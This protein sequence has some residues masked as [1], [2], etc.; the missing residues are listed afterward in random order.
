MGL[1]DD[2]IREHL[3]L[4]RRHGADPDEVSRQED[5]ALG[6]VRREPVATEEE[7]RPGPQLVDAAHEVD[8]DL[9][10]PAGALPDDLPPMTEQA[11]QLHHAPE[12]WG[13]DDDL[14]AEEPEA[15]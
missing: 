1:L 13:F 7:A 2:A 12:E 10:P 3:Q 4:K 8:D 5:E 6:P 15:E 14:E 11:T 9:E